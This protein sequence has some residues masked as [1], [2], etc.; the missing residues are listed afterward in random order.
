MAFAR[1]ATRRI[2]SQILGAML[3]CISAVASL[4]VATSA[5]ARAAELSTART[6][7]AHR[8]LRWTNDAREQHDLRPLRD[9]RRLSRYATRHSERMLRRGSLFHS[10]STRMGDA[11]S[12]TGWSMWGENVGVGPSL[13]R[14][15]RAFMHSTEHR[16][17]ILRRAFDHAGIGVVRSDGY[18]WVTV[19]FYAC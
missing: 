17:N 5:D 15:Q 7:A 16:D 11:L 6:S 4:G 9:R 10:T 14:V 3:L 12:G 2:R 1:A 19:D 18:V 13:R 8:L